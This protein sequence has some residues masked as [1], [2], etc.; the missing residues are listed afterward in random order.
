MFF[1]AMPRDRFPVLSSITP[2]MFNHGG[3]ARF[4]FGLDILIA[5][6]EAAS[7]TERAASS[8]GGEAS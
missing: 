1:A 2:V 4:E 7:A 3:E 8:T 6:M 5:G